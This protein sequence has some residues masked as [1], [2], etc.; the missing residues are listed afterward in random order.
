[1]RIAEEKRVVNPVPGGRESIFTTIGYHIHG[2]IS[3]LLLAAN[4]AFCFG[5]LM[6]A[7]LL[8]LAVPI[9]GWRKLCGKVINGIAKG[10]ISV[11][12]LN[13]NLTKGIRWDVRG[14]D[15]LSMKQW[16]LV[17][18]NHQTWSD[19]V[20]LQKVFNRKIPFLKFFL[21]KELIWVPLLGVAWWA[22]DFPFMKRYS[23]AFLKKFPHLRGKDIEI[24][25]KACRKF[26]KIPV[27]VMNFV[28]GTRFTAKK[29]IGQKSPF[30]HLLRPKAGGVG[31]VLT[32]MGEQL[33]SILNVTIVYPGGDTR[34]WSFLSGRV[35]EVRVLVEKIPITA[36]LLGDYIEDKEYQARFQEWLNTVWI[37]KDA[38]LET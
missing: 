9:D 31:F 2:A 13:I 3:V 6:T 12:N 14:M 29:H 37:R 19:I 22:L 24:T 23:A 32:T 35:R 20:V 16:Y 18:A 8:K 5:P 28:E 11:N 7:A 10:W 25:R 26:E 21:K 38:L 30:K 36:E 34:F 27:S 15:D 1:M 17:I 4:T 33:R